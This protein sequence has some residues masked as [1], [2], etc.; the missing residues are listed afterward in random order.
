M[1]LFLFH[2]GP[3]RQ[4]EDIEAQNQLC[5]HDDSF[6]VFACSTEERHAVGRA[7][8]GPCQS[9]AELELTCLAVIIAFAKHGSQRK[10]IIWSP[11]VPELKSVA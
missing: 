6:F 2:T 1:N 4:E 3:H 11:Q 10:T 9:S 7:V 5:D 8:L